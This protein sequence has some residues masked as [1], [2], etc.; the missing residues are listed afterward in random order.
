M[1]TPEGALASNMMGGQLTNLPYE[2]FVTPV[3]YNKKLLKA[4][5]YDEFPATYDEFFQNVRSC[6]CNWQG[7]HISN[8]S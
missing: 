4:A 8:D 5:G 2:L 3:T 1:F 6:Y 7:M